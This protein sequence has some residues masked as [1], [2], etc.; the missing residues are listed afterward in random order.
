[1]IISFT[2]D[3][4]DGSLARLEKPT[5]FGG[6]LDIFCDRTVEICLL[7]AIISTNPQQPLW[8]GVF[9]LSAIVLCISIFLLIG[10]AVKVEQIEKMRDDKKVIY[11]SGGIM[12]RTETFL[13]LFFMI[14]L[15]PLRLTLM[16]IFALLIFITA[17]QRFYHAYVLFHTT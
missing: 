16:W 2:L 5:I 7:I 4:F 9:S 1:M 3:I 10:G 6:I 17:L 8:P 12:E 15:S 11:Y 13:F 14:I